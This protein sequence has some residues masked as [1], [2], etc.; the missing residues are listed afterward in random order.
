MNA[1]PA[2]QPEN[3]H[4]RKKLTSCIHATTAIARSVL[5]YWHPALSSPKGLGHQPG[6]WYARAQ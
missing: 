1:L 3:I 5:V 4:R 2:R 6:I